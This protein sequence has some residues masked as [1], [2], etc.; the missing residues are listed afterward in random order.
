M[1]NFRFTKIIA[2]VG[3]TLAKETVLSKVV[4]M[5]DA[6]TITLSMGFDDNNKK[7]I[8]TIMKLDNSK[9]IILETKGKDIRVKNTV[10]L[11]LQKGDKITLEYSEYA[12]DGDQKLY[13]DYAFLEDIA[14]GTELYFI[15]SKAVI[16]VLS[17]STDALEGEVIQIPEAKIYQ[18]DRFDFSVLEYHADMISERDQ[19]DI[20]R[21]LEYGVHTF[22]LSCTSSVEHYQSI[23]DF[24]A[25]NNAKNVK[26]LAKIETKAGR[27]NLDTIATIADGIVLVIDSEIQYQDI[28]AL[29]A[30]IQKIKSQGRTVLIRQTKTLYDAQFEKEFQ[31]L[32][33]DLS[34][35]VVDAY[36]LETFVIEDEVFPNIELAEKILAQNEIAFPEKEVIRFEEK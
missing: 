11:S 36:M 19:K 9:T 17:T 30:L 4:N 6:F 7:Y 18:Y 35:E 13:V 28:D 8:D 1:N 21:G 16:R 22:S 31:Q 23:K 20:L 3:P 24:L 29:K 32:S 15:R 33:Q 5:V 26:V 34:E 14:V 25:E 10:N 12:Q 2:G 27:K